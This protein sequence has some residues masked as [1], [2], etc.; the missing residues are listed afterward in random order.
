MKLLLSAF[1][2]C[3]LLVLALPGR[4]ADEP[5]TPIVVFAAASLTNVLQDIGTDYTR[6][7]GQEVKFSFAASSVLARQIEAGTRADV[8]VS[9]DED[10]MDYLQSRNLIDPK[11]RHDIIM[12][13]LVL[14]APAASDIHLKIAPHFALA[15]ALG[16]ERLATG[17]PGSVPVGR[18]ARAALT[19]LGVWSEVARQIV[20]TEDVRAALAFVARGETPLGIVYETDA[21]IEKRVRIVDTFP[22]DSHAPITYPV[23]LIAT[24]KAGAGRFVGYMKSP[25]GRALFAHYGFQN[26]P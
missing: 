25:A 12:N 15:A 26:L 13:R 23:A 6:Q 9:A 17:D 5:P 20:P 8:F 4:A 16:K 21:L 7:T 11:T 1:S 19:N 2:A 22:E 3:V 18:Y 10:W 24:A 14:I